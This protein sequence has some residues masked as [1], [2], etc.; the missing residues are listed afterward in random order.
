MKLAGL[1]RATPCVCRL[2][3]CVWSW[4]RRVAEGSVVDL[5]EAGLTKCKKGGVDRDDQEY[6]FSFCSSL[7]LV[8]ALFRVVESNSGSRSG[9]TNR[10]YQ[11]AASRPRLSLIK[12][13]PSRASTVR[14][15][16]SCNV[17]ARAVS[18]LKRK[19]H[20]MMCEWLEKE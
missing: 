17:D 5:V 9:T 12:S 18:R 4:T 15:Q 2:L 20:F 8:F 6:S 13:W 19:N 3:C 1:S 10:V 11:S 7:Q 14:L 16:T